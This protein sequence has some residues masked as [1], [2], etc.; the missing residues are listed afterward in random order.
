MEIN[1]GARICQ[2]C[3]VLAW[4][5]KGART[6]KKGEKDSNVRGGSFRKFNRSEQSPLRMI[7][8]GIR[9]H[10]ACGIRTGTGF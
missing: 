10:S 9:E 1:G 7:H 6:W 4:N 5:A 2:G 3:K 8:F